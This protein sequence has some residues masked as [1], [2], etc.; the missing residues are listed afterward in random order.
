LAKEVL[1]Y[2]CTGSGRCRGRQCAQRQCPAGCIQQ[3]NPDVLWTT[4]TQ[5]LK[6]ELAAIKYTAKVK[7][8]CVV[9]PTTDLFFIFKSIFLESNEYIL[10]LKKTY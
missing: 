6:Q 3:I 1:T 5:G 10:D 2:S 8:V 9:Q 7:N 4:F